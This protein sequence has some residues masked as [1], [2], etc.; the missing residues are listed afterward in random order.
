MKANE[1]ISYSSLEYKYELHKQCHL[2]CFEQYCPFL[3]LESLT[4]G[5]IQIN[6]NRTKMIILLCGVLWRKNCFE[7][8]HGF[9]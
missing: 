9:H 2:F 3:F 5:K 7:Y 4:F 1:N 8:A 6:R